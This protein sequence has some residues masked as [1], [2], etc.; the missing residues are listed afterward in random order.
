MT[1]AEASLKGVDRPPAIKERTTKS[2]GV[3]AATGLPTVEC[4]ARGKKD[5]AQR[6][7]FLPI[8]AAG[9]ALG[10]ITTLKIPKRSLR[11]R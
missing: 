11:R 7:P 5:S 10:P 4:V 2:R 1:P 3:R 9:F 8:Y 6:L